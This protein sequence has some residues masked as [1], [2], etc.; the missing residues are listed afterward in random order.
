MDTQTFSALAEPR[1]LQIIELLREQSCSVN[2]I[3]ERLKI[4][5]PQ[6]SKHL[7]ALHKA[8]LVNVQPAAQR[9]IYSLNHEPFLQLDNWL[10]SFNDYWTTRL[11]RL[12]S[13]LKAE[14]D[15]S[16]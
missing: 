16:E 10:D 7:H 4:R 9:R 11:N 12:D 13:Y 2:D 5:Q 6:A 3:A 8:K 1:R 15:K 14:G